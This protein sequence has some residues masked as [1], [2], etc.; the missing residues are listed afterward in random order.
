MKVS[1]VT[2]S[3]NRDGPTFGLR[4]YLAALIVLFIGTAVGSTLFV[5]AQAEGAARRDVTHDVQFAADLAA[6]EV[7]DSLA[8]LGT[9]I[10]QTSGDR[11]GFRCAT[12]V[13]QSRLRRRGRL[14]EDA[15]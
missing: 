12:L 11:R 10:A 2:T 14:S 5:R 3:G 4:I 1:R 8:A 7:A 9:T 15:P 13:V 6:S